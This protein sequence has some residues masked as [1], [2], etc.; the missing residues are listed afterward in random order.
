[1]IAYYSNLSSLGLMMLFGGNGSF[2]GPFQS[3]YSSNQ[4]P[5]VYAQDFCPF[6]ERLLLTFVNKKS[7][8]LSVTR[9]LGACFPSAILLAIVTVVIYASN[10]C[11][12]FPIFRYVFYVRLVHVFSKFVKGLPQTYNPS[13]TIPFIVK[14]A[15]FV[16]STPHFQ[17]NPVESVPR[18]FVA[19]NLKPMPSLANA[20]E[21]SAFYGVHLS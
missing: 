14:R 10:R 20:Y 9:L 6:W 16:A 7:T 17:V 8:S 2:K 18:I 11:L 1:M 3:V 13:T 19:T 21:S 5:V 12:L 4:E 15:L